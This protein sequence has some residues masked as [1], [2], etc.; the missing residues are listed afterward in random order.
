MIANTS[1]TARCVHKEW[2]PV[3]A[4]AWINRVDAFEARPTSSN[5]RKGRVTVTN[6]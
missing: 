5:S 1:G 4:E 3:T 2:Q 6:Q